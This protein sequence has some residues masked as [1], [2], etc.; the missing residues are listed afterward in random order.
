MSEIRTI[1]AHGTTSPCGVR[2]RPVSPIG[3]PLA[4]IPIQNERVLVLFGPVARSLPTS[5]VDETARA[6]SQNA[7]PTGGRI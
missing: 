4:A 1:L 3:E 6:D 7:V 5:G 2:V